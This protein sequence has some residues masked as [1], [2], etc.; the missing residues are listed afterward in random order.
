MLRRLAAA[1]CLVAAALTLV[2]VLAPP[3]PPQATAVVAAADLPA[4]HLVQESDLTT[5]SGPVGLPG[6][7]I[8]HS[9]DAVGRRLAAP[10]ATGELVTSS[11]LVPR[12]VADGL[13]ADLVAMHLL[14]ADPFSLDLVTP[15][16]RVTLHGLDGV[17]MATSV[18]V[19]S[20]DPAQSG[21]GLDFAASAPT[22]RPT[23]LVVALPRTWVPRLLTPSGADTRGPTVHLV[24][25]SSP[26]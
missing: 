18:R 26:P 24:L 20:L 22:G 16:S 15:G 21:A 4:G 12:S 8:R 6:P 13:P 9:A 5:W 2:R 7:V 1:A 14:V 10:L 3:A 25:E 17:E 19:L 11:H 23:G